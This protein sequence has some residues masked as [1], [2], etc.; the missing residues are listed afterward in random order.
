MNEIDIVKTQISTWQN[1]AWM[2][3][4]QGNQDLVQQ[5]LTHKHRYEKRLAEL[6][7]TDPPDEPHVDSPFDDDPPQGPSSETSGV[8]RRPLPTAGGNAI[9]LPLPDP[10]K[11]DM[12]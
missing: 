7:G 4:Q 9:A 12:A 10:E 3:S 11:D 2:A 6:L 5:A 8:P 1:R